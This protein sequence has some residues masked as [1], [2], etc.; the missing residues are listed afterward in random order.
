MDLEERELEILA[1][2]KRAPAVKMAGLWSYCK[3][4]CLTSDKD[5]TCVANLF[6]GDTLDARKREVDRFFSWG[7]IK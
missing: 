4:T 1:R 6:P 7:D 5:C 2:K 3:G